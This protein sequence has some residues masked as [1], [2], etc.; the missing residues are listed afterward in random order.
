MAAAVR[1]AARAPAARREQA[2]LA[3]RQSRAV[4]GRPARPA[5][6][7]RRPAR[8]PVRGRLDL[9]RLLLHLLQLRG[10]QVRTDDLQRH[11]RAG[12][13]LPGRRRRHDGLGRR[14]QW[15]GLGRSW[16]Q[17]RR[18]G[19]RRRRRQRRRG[20][21]GL[22]NRAPHNRHG[23][24][25]HVQLQLD[26]LCRCNDSC[27]STFRC[28]NGRFEFLGRRRLP[29]RSPAFQTTRRGRHSRLCTF[30][31]DQTCNDDPRSSCD[32]SMLHGRRHLRVRRRGTNP[33]SGRCLYAGRR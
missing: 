22:S 27:Y 14:G 4:G 26:D 21:H 6:R 9:S 13:A 7:L 29:A 1:R 18:R 25:R 2:A 23:V 24:H 20:G 3:A 11:L 16:R 5:R 19:Q 32:P 8:L 10:R 30:G 28:T 17:C 15:R 12:P 31:A 33:D